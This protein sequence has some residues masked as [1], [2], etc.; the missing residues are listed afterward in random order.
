MNTTGR[1]ALDQVGVVVACYIMLGAELEFVPLS[2]HFLLF[3]PD[4]LGD[5]YG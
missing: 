4:W 5:T 3:L 1:V 2:E